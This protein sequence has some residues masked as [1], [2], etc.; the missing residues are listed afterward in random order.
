[1]FNVV[2]TEFNYNQTVQLRHFDLACATILILFSHIDIYILN[3]NSIELK[4]SLH[5]GVST[6]WSE[7]QERR[8]FVVCV[9]ESNIVTTL[10]L[11]ILASN[12]TGHVLQWIKRQYFKF[13]PSQE[14][15]SVFNA[16]KSPSRKTRQCFTNTCSGLTCHMILCKALRYFHDLW[17]IALTIGG[18][19]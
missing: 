11:V 5:S 2:A 18:K 13:C 3:V 10:W 6:K 17:L 14:I 7:S 8:R 16:L 15:C 4:S 1:M 9:V 12:I 19:D